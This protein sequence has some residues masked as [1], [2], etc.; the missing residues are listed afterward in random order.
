MCTSLQLNWKQLVSLNLFHSFSTGLLNILF[1][2]ILVMNVAEKCVW[3]MEV[4]R[5]CNTLV[6]LPLIFG[7][8]GNAVKILVCGSPE[9]R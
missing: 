4:W 7:V 6:L 8:C 5:V 1:Y 3:S 9:G 2:F